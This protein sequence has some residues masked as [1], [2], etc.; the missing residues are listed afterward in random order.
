MKKFLTVAS[1]ALLTVLLAITFAGCGNKTSKLQK[2]YEKA[3]YTCEVTTLTDDEKKE[4]EDAIKELDGDEKKEMQELYDV[5]KKSE[6]LEVKKDGATVV[7]ITY[8]PN[9]KDNFS[10]IAGEFGGSTYDAAEKLGM[11]KGDFMYGG[12]P[13]GDAFQIFKDN[14]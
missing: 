1:L 8:I 10:K 11:V 12:S 2:A 3:G 6:A 14:A 4:Y 5:M 9:L 13:I 7:I